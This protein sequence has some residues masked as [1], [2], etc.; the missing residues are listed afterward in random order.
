MA[1]QIKCPG[2]QTTIEVS[3]GSRGGGKCPQ[4]GAVLPVPAEAAPAP[5]PDLTG[6]IILIVDDDHFIKLFLQ[7]T[8]KKSGA[9]VSTARDGEVALAIAKAEKPDLIILDLA[10]PGAGGIAVLP[11]LAACND[12]KPTPIIVMTA[13]DPATHKAAAIRAGAKAFVHKPVL[14]AELIDAIRTALGGAA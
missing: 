3:G 13:S 10:M 8:L 11:A 2:C 4:C 7:A 9:M 14:A 12:A 1:I 6:K 5:M